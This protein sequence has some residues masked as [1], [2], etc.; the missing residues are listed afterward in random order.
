MPGISVGDAVL[1]LGVD[2]R[3]LDKGMQGLGA[4]IK[5]HNKAIGLAMV[6]TG[7]IILGISAATIR[8]AS[9]VE[10]M[11]AK[12]DTVFKESAENVRN[13]ADVTAKAMGRSRFAFMEMAASVQ[14]TFVPMGFARDK[15]AEMS[16]TLTEL[17]VDVASFNNKLDIDVMRDFQSA[18][19]GNTETVRKYGIVITA[20]MVEQEIINQV[21]VTSKDQITEAMKVQARLN[22]I[23]KGTTDAQ[24]DAIRTSDSFANR[25]KAMKAA[26]E[27][28]TVTIGTELLPIITPF[29]EKITE[30]VGRMVDWTKEHPKL[31]E[32][33]IKGTTALGLFLLPLGA[34]IIALPQIVAAYK[35][36]SGFMVRTLIPR[37][38]AL[39]AVIWAKVAAIV[40][41]IAACGPA[42]WA[43]AL[44]AVAAITASLIIV[45]QMHNEQ[46]EKLT[47]TTKTAKEEQDEHTEA[48][49]SGID[50]NLG[51]A[52]SIGIV[53][54]EL[55][56]EMSLLQAVGRAFPGGAPG[57]TFAGIAGY[58]YL[59]QHPEFE[60]RFRQERPREYWDIIG[61]AVERGERMVSRL[62]NGGIAMSPMRAV[63]AE[64]KPEAV[65]PLDRLS[66]MLGGTSGSNV[67][68]IYLDGAE[69][70]NTLVRRMT[71]NVKLQGG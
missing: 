64:K 68:H 47:E 66:S 2:T 37:I 24:G 29:V 20:A 62:A 52:A 27:E 63:I 15:A 14:D 12:F 6:A 71:T 41:S 42:G 16:K 50:A 30:T 54:Q 5:Q 60:K 26:I 7:G 8:A 58:E 23:L 4:K 46:L 9:D 28:L 36:M 70:G 48:V 11:T 44:G 31:T 17:A 10:E 19:V 38:V 22:L 59:T 43:L 56:R 32:V 40:A 49:K 3:D 55:T 18:L 35:I 65:I 67:F 45:N 39:T 33:I 51:L 61:E 1:K 25:T 21:W 57:G 13:W 34:L 69:V 53:N